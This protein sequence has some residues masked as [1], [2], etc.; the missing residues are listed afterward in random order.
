MLLKGIHDHVPISIALSSNEDDVDENKLTRESSEMTTATS[1]TLIASNKMP[2]R[3]SELTTDTS[4]TLPTSNKLAINSALKSRSFLAM[5]MATIM[6]TASELDGGNQQFDPEEE[7]L[8]L[9]IESNKPI[10]RRNSFG[11]DHSDSDDEYDSECSSL[12]GLEGFDDDDVVSYATEYFPF[13]SCATQEP[14]SANGF[15]VA[16]IQKKFFQDGVCKQSS[17]LFSEMNDKEEHAKVSTG[18]NPS[19]ASPEVS[20]K[21]DEDEEAI[22]SA[23]LASTRLDTLGR[24]STPLNVAEEEVESEILLQ[25]YQKNMFGVVRSGGSNPDAFDP[26]VRGSGVDAGTVTSPYHRSSSTAT[27]NT[28]TPYDSQIKSALGVAKESPNQAKAIPYYSEEESEEYGTDKSV[29]ESLKSSRMSLQTNEEILRNIDKCIAVS[30]KYR[31]RRASQDL[32]F[33]HQRPTS[34]TSLSKSSQD[35]LSFGSSSSHERN[36]SI[37][38]PKQSTSEQ[39]LFETSLVSLDQSMDLPMFNDWIESVFVTLHPA[40]ELYGSKA[41][42]KSSTR[43]YFSPDVAKPLVDDILSTLREESSDN[44]PSH[45]VGKRGYVGSHSEDRLRNGY[46]VYRSRGGQEYRGEWKNGKKEGF[47]IAS[48]GTGEYF[49]GWKDNKREGHGIM[50]IHTGDVFEGEWS[51]HAKNGVGAYHYRDGETDVSFYKDDKRVG[52]GVRWGSERRKLYLLNGSEVVRS[53]ITMDEA[54]QIL[55]SFG[56]GLLSSK[57]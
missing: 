48:Y 50:A 10:H 57:T 4:A 26:E 17:S 2:K 29:E 54:K 32:P 28:S 33:A 56:A 25:R 37:A 20:P 6:S 36:A 14:T 3:N 22:V 7:E 46:G 51:A 35:S 53:N 5:S 19:L 13:N 39:Q 43:V 34:T 18:V 24:N 41:S 31:S 30:S 15:I 52:Y 44:G 8:V 9:N 23:F 11:E 42:K 12:E 27:R 47:G 40:S 21:V 55:N 16:D 1:A 45:D 38:N 49:G